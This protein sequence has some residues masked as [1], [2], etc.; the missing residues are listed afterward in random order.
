MRGGK[1]TTSIFLLVP[2]KTLIKQIFCAS[3]RT[4]NKKK[5]EQDIICSVNLKNRKKKKNQENR[6]KFS[7]E[8]Q[9]LFEKGK[10]TL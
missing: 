3:L 9:F 1:S 2:N 5:N 6:D 7:K 8:S 4:E 10:A